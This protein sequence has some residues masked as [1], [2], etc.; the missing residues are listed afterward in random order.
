MS[1]LGSL[2]VCCTDGR[3]G[4]RASS[5]TISP[6]RSRAYAARWAR[7][8][9]RLITASRHITGGALGNSRPFGLP[10][11]AS[12]CAML[13]PPR[14][15]SFTSLVRKALAR[16]IFGPQKEWPRDEGRVTYGAFG[17]CG[18]QLAIDSG[19][20]QPYGSYPKNAICGEIAG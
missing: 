4:P 20:R 15:M 1:R 12:M 13:S 9:A 6:S 17:S 18:G 8:G 3:S 2:A 16:L 5:V 11:R 14:Y 7:E 19:P 10:K